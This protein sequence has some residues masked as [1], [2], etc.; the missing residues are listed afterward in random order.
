MNTLT[1][2]LEPYM[3]TFGYRVFDEIAVY[4]A[5][6][7]ANGLFGDKMASA[8]KAAFDSA[9]LMKVLPKFY[10]SLARLRATA[11]RVGPLRPSITSLIGRSQVHRNILSH[12]WSAASSTQSSMKRSLGLALP[13]ANRARD[14]RRDRLASRALSRLLP[15]RLPSIS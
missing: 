9:V 4:V 14:E 1:H 13:L 5:L 2:V 3:L 11:R 8:A 15:S 6:A 10:G 12:P 7:R